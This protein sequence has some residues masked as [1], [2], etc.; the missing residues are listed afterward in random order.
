MNKK[1]KKTLLFLT[2][3]LIISGMVMLFMPSIVFPASVTPELIDPWD[4]SGGADAECGR[5]TGCGCGDAYKVD[6]WTPSGF[7][8]DG[9]TITISGDAKTFDW[10]ST[11]HV[12]CVIVKAGTGAYIFRYPGGSYGDNG[13]YAPQ[14]KDISH[15]T[16]CWDPTDT[17]T[18]TEATTT[19]TESTTTTTEPTTTTTE[20]TTTTTQPATTTTST[21]TTTE[22]TTTTTA[23]TT[24]TTAGTTT[25][26]KG[27]TTTTKGTTTTTPTTGGTTTTGT[28]QVLAF[29]GYNSLWYVAGS[30]LIA[31]G[32]IMGTFSL[33]TTLRKR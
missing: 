20:P 16:F 14:N 33:S 24:T 10:T 32:I 27:T 9:Q 8:H 22:G 6:P 11:K 4:P 5:A 15:V 29:T 21:T 26:T 2:S 12:C 25:T 18:T 7:T 1:F 30:I 23:G 28:I 13:L 19:T 31:L 3:F 17:T